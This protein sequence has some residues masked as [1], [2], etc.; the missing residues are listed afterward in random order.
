MPCAIEQAFECLTARAE[1]NTSSTR[2]LKVP[3][4]PPCKYLDSMIDLFFFLHETSSIST[5]TDHIVGR[6]RVKVQIH[7]GKLQPSLF[8]LDP[9]KINLTDDVLLLQ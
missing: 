4:S 2:F 7:F 3:E 6:Q 5:E 8:Y 1:T 9:T